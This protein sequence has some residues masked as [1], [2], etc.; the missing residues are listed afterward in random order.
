MK[1]NFTNQ[2]TNFSALLWNFGDNTATST[3]TN[4]V[5]TYAD[6]G[7]YTVTL[8]ATSTDGKVTDVF[9]A[10]VTITDPDAELTKL[11][12]EGNDGKLWKLIRVGTTGRYPIEVGPF[13]HSTDLVGN[14]P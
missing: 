8:T 11:V 7:A 3:E 10:R 6:L 12:G 13:D 1:V 2:S 14:G 4:P 9:T 5:H